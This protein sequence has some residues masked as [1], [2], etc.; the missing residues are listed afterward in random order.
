MGL[1][2]LHQPWSMPT[3]V[4]SGLMYAYPTR[5]LRSAW[6]GVFLHSTA[7]V[8]IIGAVLAIVLR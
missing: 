5:R 2:H 8:V 1:Y 3:S 6:M 4:L 7:S